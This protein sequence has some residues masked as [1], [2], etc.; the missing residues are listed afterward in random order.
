[1]ILLTSLKALLVDSHSEQGPGGEV[2]PIYYVEEVVPEFHFT[3]NSI[4]SLLVNIQLEIGDF[5][6]I[7]VTK[8]HPGD[9]KG[10]GEIA[11]IVL[12]HLQIHGGIRPVAWIL[13][14][15]VGFEQHSSHPAGL[16]LS[17]VVEAPG[18]ILPD[19]LRHESL[20]HL[21]AALLQVC[22]GVEVEEGKK[23]GENLSGQS[24]E[25]ISV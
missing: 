23:V 11:I 2:G 5:G 10:I 22:H 16:E 18:V 19:V 4:F 15:G 6:P 14:F 9:N 7:L 1:M 25:N 13:D 24:E 21:P 20:L 12:H 17:L 3:W 8:M